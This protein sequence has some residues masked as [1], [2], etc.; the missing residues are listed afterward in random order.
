MLGDILDSTFAKNPDFA[1]IPQRL[2]IFRP[3][4][5]SVAHAP[6]RAAR[7]ACQTRALVARHVEVGEAE[8]ASASMGES[9][10]LVGFTPQRGTVFLVILCS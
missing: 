10:W 5:Q 9:G 6:L 3:G 2:A 1:R 4:S 7:I 8:W